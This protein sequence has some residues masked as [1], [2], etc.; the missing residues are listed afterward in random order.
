M[1]RADVKN[2]FILR[3][4]D[5]LSRLGI[6][7]PL[8]VMTDSDTVRLSNAFIASSNILD[9]IQLEVISGD[10]TRALSTPRTTRNK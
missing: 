4:A 2:M 10:I 7:M 3:E 8:D 5:G 6:Q 1:K 9:F